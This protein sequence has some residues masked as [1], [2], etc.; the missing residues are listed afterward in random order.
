MSSHYKLPS[1]HYISDNVFICIAVSCLTLFINILLKPFFMSHYSVCVIYCI[2]TFID[3]LNF[4]TLKEAR[5][6]LVQ[7]GRE[8]IESCKKRP[9]EVASRAL[10][11]FRRPIH[12]LQLTILTHSRLVFSPSNFNI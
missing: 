8:F 11:L 1:F 9:Y 10:V 4:Q 7:R 6:I 3:I 2:N 12:K 5:S